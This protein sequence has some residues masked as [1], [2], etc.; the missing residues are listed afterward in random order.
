M[1][2]LKASRCVRSLS[3]ESECNRCEL[4]CSTEAIVVGSNPLPSINFSACVGCGACDAVCPNEAL[5]LDDF[6]TT[7]FFFSFMEDSDNLISCRKNVPCIAAL[8]VENII[9]MALLKKEMVFDMGHCDE[10][11]IAHKCRPEIE[12]NYE[13]AS[14]VLEAMQSG[15][16]IKLE[17]VKHEKESS[18][19]E[20]TSNRR[21]FFSKVNLAGAIKAKQQ[22][23][24]EIQKA[25][26]ELVEHTLQKSDIAL[27]KQKRITDRRK[28]FFTALKRVEK[29][30]VYHIIEADELTF[31]SSKEIN[32]ETCTACQ[33]C[34]RV[35]P[36]GA[37]SS[38]IKNSKIEFDPFLCI[39]CHICHD[40]CVPEAIKLS[41]TYRVK[42]FFEPEVHSL[43]KF[44]V[45]RCDECNV[46]FS[47]NSDERLCYRCKAEEEEA[48]ALWGI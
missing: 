4:I 41:S 29:P 26:D 39:K 34:Y 2:Q 1:I 35:C 44:N 24:K 48:R 46:I 7:D 27:L 3:K 12:K 32:S 38:D 47:T 13:E 25:T 16:L 33:M 36:S 5:S 18:G 23:E 14:Y 43:I 11:A 6:S 21:E 30:E 8:N 31:T 15:A 19:E 20:S 45:R 17:D 42:E 40:V 22:F 9:S 10:C 28:L 37:L